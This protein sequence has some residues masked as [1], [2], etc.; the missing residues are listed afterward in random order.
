MSGQITIRQ[1]VPEDLSR[2]IEIEN[3]C[4]PADM[5]YP[6][7][8]FYHYIAAP[9][10]FFYVALLHHRFAGFVIAGEI[11]TGEAWIVTLDVHPGS[12]R[13]G[14]GE[15]LIRHIEGICLRDGIDR[16][17][18]QVAVDNSPAL[19]LYEKLGYKKSDHLA[20]YYRNGED[21]FIMEKR[22][23]APEGV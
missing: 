15:N 16:L 13:R 8:L 12:R 23:A 21:A 2:I 22:I 9:A 4:F 17:I 6:P 10:H 20:D 3:L 18:L 5:A 14:V 11:E 7:D 19:C 1:A